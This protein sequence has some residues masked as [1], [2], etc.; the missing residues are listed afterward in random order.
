MGEYITH[1]GQQIKLGTCED[2]Y[3][4]TFQQLVKMARKSGGEAYHYL[5]LDASGTGRYRFRFPFPRE[6]NAEDHERSQTFLWGKVLA[7][8]EDFDHNGICHSTGNHSPRG[9]YNV[10]I[11][12]KCP[13]SHD[14]KEWAK[15]SGVMHSA[16]TP[17]STL[18]GI[19]QQRIVENSLWTVIECAYCKAKQRLDKAE[20]LKLA[21]AIRHQ[22]SGDDQTHKWWRSLADEIEAGYNTDV[23]AQLSL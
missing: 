11:V 12:F 2:L 21:D 1:N 13:G 16:I 7:K 23:R 18:I 5:K 8:D 6:T 22:Y 4:V 19:C 15:D 20:G 14:F 9:C 17:S 10:N 3:Y